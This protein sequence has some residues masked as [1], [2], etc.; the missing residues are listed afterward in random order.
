MDRACGGLCHLSSILRL[1]A[2]IE[3]S[4]CARKYTRHFWLPV[5]QTSVTFRYMDP[6]TK[7]EIAETMSLQA[8]ELAA[9]Y[10]AIP[11]NVFFSK[12][13]KGWSPAGNIRHLDKAAFALLAGL[14]TPKPM[15]RLLFG[16]C[17]RG[18]RRLSEIRD[19]YLRRLSQGAGAGI[20]TPVN[21]GGSGATRTKQKLLAIFPSNASRL[22]KA[23]NRFSDEELD[24]L[25]LPHPIL[26]RVPLR[27]M[28]LFNILHNEHHTGI[29]RR[30]MGH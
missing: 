19:S 14:Y 5:L 29:V 12:P 27:E 16:K 3:S 26:G 2:A 6:F 8:K 1:A 25:Q 30:R 15:L 17:R 13:A 10:E 23:M 18:V 21:K 28:M 24:S 7:Q 22:A 9:Y 11:D 4:A 20:Y